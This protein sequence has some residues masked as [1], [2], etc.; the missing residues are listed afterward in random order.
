MTVHIYTKSVVIKIF[1]AFK[2][3][4]MFV[5]T[6][7]QNKNIKHYLDIFYCF[8]KFRFWIKCSTKKKKLNACSFE[9]RV[10]EKKGT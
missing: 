5:Q 6:S 2:L 9:L 10:W 7:R 4:E 1:K 3:N 8:R